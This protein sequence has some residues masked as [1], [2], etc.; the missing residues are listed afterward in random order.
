MGAQTEKVVLD[1]VS[2]FHQELRSVVDLRR[3][4]AEIYEN[5]NYG[6]A[7]PSP[8]PAPS[9][10]EMP[11]SGFSQAPRQTSDQ[12]TTLRRVPL[13]HMSKSSGSAM[14]P[15]QEDPTQE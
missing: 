15:I 2:K 13:G 8:P 5:P 4:L 14:V 9:A 6:V 12:Q 1:L 10:L 11:A 3:Q 7:A